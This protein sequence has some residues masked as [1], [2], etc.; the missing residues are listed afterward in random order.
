MIGTCREYLVGKLRQAGIK[1]TVHTSMKKLKASQESHIGAVL[2]E[3][4]SFIR[5]FGKR[6][7]YD[8]TG[9]HKRRKQFAR[10]TSFVVVIGEYEQEA[11]ERIFENFMLSLDRGIYIDGNFTEIEPGEAD[12][13]DEEDSIL[14]SK[15]AVQLKV[16]FL[17]GLYRDSDFAKISELDAEVQIEKEEEHG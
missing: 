7:Y 17:G 9:K 11:C 1:S 5:E 12:W 8:E 10:E 2:F 13:V 14:K 15:I 6:I 16:K 3:G 4:D